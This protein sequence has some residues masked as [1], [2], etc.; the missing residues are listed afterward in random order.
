[1]KLYIREHVFTWSDE[2]TVRDETG[3]E[4]YTVSGEVFTWGKK[5]HVYDRAGNEVAYIRQELLTWLPC[6]HVYVNGAETA[7]IRQKFSFFHPRYEV[8]GPGWCVEGEFFAHDFEITCN[9]RTVAALHKQWMTWGDCYELDIADP[10]DELTALA[11]LVV[12][13]CVE[14][15]NN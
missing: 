12:I 1:M 5:L 13:D 11:V 3:A 6:Y 9:G 10:A 7:Q 15:S 8:D 2:F 4:K 14:E